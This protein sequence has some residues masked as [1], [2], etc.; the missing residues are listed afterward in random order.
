MR[1][2]LLNTILK[3]VRKAKTDLAKAWDLLRSLGVTLPTTLNTDSLPDAIDSL[4][5]LTIA[6]EDELGVCTPTGISFANS[7]E[8]EINLEHLSMAD[9][10]GNKADLSFTSAHDLENVIIGDAMNADAVHFSFQHCTSIKRLDLTRVGNFDATSWY[11]GFY[12]MPNLEWLDI[13]NLSFEKV[14]QIGNFWDNINTKCK[15]IIGDN[16][17]RD[18]EDGLVATFCGMKNT[19]TFF[20]TIYVC[21]L[22]YSSILSVFKGIADL[23]G[24]SQKEISMRGIY[25]NTLRSD[26]D[27]IPPTDVLEA[28]RNELTQ[29]ANAKNWTIRL[30]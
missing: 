3:R 10:V 14:T 29:I 26:D 6:P 9:C 15:T 18:V 22:R 20:S 30:F 11:F 24:E 1:V 17:L 8:T 13:T 21:N 12:D 19:F 23:S 27:T 25:W 28:R 2:D 7:Q 4:P 16:T 5:M